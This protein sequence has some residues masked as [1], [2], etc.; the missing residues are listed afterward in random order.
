M[1]F[2]HHVSTECSHVSYAID[3]DH[4]C[5]TALSLAWMTA[6]SGVSFMVTLSWWGLSFWQ[7]SYL[8]C[9]QKTAFLNLSSRISLGKTLPPVFNCPWNSFFKTKVR[10]GNGGQARAWQEFLCPMWKM[11]RCTLVCHLIP[12]IHTSRLL[13]NN[14]FFLFLEKYPSF[15][16]FG[17]AV[18]GIDSIQYFLFFKLDWLG[19]LNISFSYFQLNYNWLWRKV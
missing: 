11:H 2:D 6:A 17:G 14:P 16:I 15:I 19:F 9:F 3:S 18:C 13:I 12:S 4:T 7:F 8:F 5:P 1:S 10:Y